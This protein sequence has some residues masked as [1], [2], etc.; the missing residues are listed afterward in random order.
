MK[1]ITLTLLL[2]CG[3]CSFAQSGFIEVEVTDT[4]WTRPVSFDFN[5]TVKDNWN[6]Y[7][8]IATG[9]DEDEA[10]QFDEKAFE[11]ERNLK[12]EAL[13]T[14]LTKKKYSFNELSEDNFNLY[15]QGY[16][17]GYAITLKNGKDL[18]R[19]KDDLKTLDYVDG[20][21]AKPVFATEATYDAAIFKKLINSAQSK[22]KAIAAVTGQKVGK[23]TEVKEI[24]KTQADFNLKDIYY[25]M[26]EG[27]AIKV[28]K[29]GSVYGE[30]S[31]TITVKFATE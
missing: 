31:K 24:G 16:Q 18:Q 21:I 23:I 5:V 15:G 3:L 12:L 6:I 27:N 29:D 26:L 1:N 22:V 30:I 14:F 8:P 17:R 9:M 2:L 25:T 4:L 28:A 20:N 11:A 19:L 7:P 10:Y 13:K